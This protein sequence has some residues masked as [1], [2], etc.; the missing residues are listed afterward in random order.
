MDFGRSPIGSIAYSHL[1]MTE[2]LASPTPL[3]ADR[4][5]APLP[6]HGRSRVV[7]ENVSPRVDD[8]RFVVKSSV[9]ETVGG[10]G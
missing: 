3:Q 4:N 10:D 8:G 7:I 2:A 6:Q 1:G 9:G 5:A